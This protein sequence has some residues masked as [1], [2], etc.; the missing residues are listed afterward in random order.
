MSDEL[1]NEELN[2]K[3]AEDTLPEELGEDTIPEVSAEELALK[4]RQLYER[5]K[6]AEAKAK[7]LEEQL[8]K[9][10]ENLSTNRQSAP[11]SP[12]TRTDYERLELKTEGFNSSE[13]DFLMQNGGKK[14]TENPIVMAGIEALRK[15]NKS[16]EATP[17][18]TAKSPVYQK[19]T[20]EDL[21]KMS[22]EELEKIVPR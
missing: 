19:F 21:R 4:N 5:T 16:L 2:S 15:K 1:N 20:S 3:S 10:Q 6:K 8:K 18:G 9:N 22:A 17:A 14:A 7:E 13:I 12:I 11:D